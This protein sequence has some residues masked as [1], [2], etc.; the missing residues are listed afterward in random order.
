MPKR[1]AAKAIHWNQRPA[2]ASSR[3]L[4]EGADL[5]AAVLAGVLAA[6]GAEE[7]GMARAAALA[8]PAFCSSRTRRSSCCCKILR[9][10]SEEAGRV[11][12]LTEEDW[13]RKR[14]TATNP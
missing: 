10:S 7:A 4:P 1:R 3:V 14:M 12:Y 5:A 11:L 2:T 8:I 13:V 6:G 9:N